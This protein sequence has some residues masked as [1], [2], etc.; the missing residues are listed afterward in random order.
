MAVFRSRSSTSMSSPRILYPMDIYPMN[1][2]KS[3]QEMVRE[4][5]IRLTVKDGR[6]EWWW[7][8]F[9]LSN[10]YFFRIINRS[11]GCKAGEH[12]PFYVSKLSIYI[13]SVFAS[14]KDEVSNVIRF[15][16]VFFFFLHHTGD[17]HYILICFPS[18]TRKRVLL[19]QSAV[20]S[21]EIHSLHLRDDYKS[22]V[23]IH[24]CLC[25]CVYGVLW[26]LKRPFSST[27]LQHIFLF[28]LYQSATVWNVLHKP[29]S[30][31]KLCQRQIKRTRQHNTTQ[32]IL[33][34]DCT[35]KIQVQRFHSLY[36]PFLLLN[37]KLYMTLHQTLYLFSNSTKSKK[38]VWS[39]C[40]WIEFPQNPVWK[41]DLLQ[42]L[43]GIIKKGKP[44]EARPD[45]LKKMQTMVY[46]T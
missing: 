14:Q 12:L 30:E 37:Q 3:V 29:T 9:R 39:K 19:K 20:A 7:R 13:C 31:H 40:I 6:R 16:W 1:S 45:K 23:L 42:N 41:L 18:R 44:K 11:V 15:M 46:K 36:L 43:Y 5:K 35:M 24:R 34:R 27:Q 21:D 17:W 38:D 22:D 2:L 4:N 25:V 8:S 10:R 26:A 32:I 33:F 28:V